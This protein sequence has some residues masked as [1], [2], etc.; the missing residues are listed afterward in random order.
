MTGEE[1]KAMNYLATQTCNITFKTD[2]L[3]A[4]I[5]TEIAH[6]K[7]ITQP[8]LIDEICK[9]YIAAKIVKLQN[10]NETP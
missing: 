2:R 10:N 9:Y 5:L 3:T 1:F 4:H 8:K 6:E 7:G